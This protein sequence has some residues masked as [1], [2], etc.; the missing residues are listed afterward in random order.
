M[1]VVRSNY[2]RK[3]ND[4][5]ETEEWATEALL[6]HFPVA[7]MRVW[8]PAAGNHKMAD[9]LRK[10]GAGFVL[11]SDITTYSRPHFEEFDFIHAEETR[12]YGYY[13]DRSWP[14]AIITNPPFGKG[15]RDAVRF[16]ELALERCDGIV[17]M[18]LPDVFD[19]GKTRT[20]LFRDNP[21][22]TSKIN[23]IDRIQ[24]FP[25]KFG[26]TQN[27]AWYVWCNKG[28]ISPNLYYEGKKP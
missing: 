2:E 25:G 13:R 5:Y 3:A 22:F 26:N 19:F 15:G 18:L 14:D 16:V 12:V 24:W 1:T 9:V 11:T 17:A 10:S 27:H 20:H 7:G 23:L 8:E 4:L 6:R 28:K 21:R